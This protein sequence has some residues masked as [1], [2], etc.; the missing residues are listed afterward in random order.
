LEKDKLDEYIQDYVRA[1]ADGGEIV[2]GWV[3]CA[4]VQHAGVAHSDGYIVDTSSGMPYHT[5]IGLLTAGLE[6]KKNI[7]LSQTL[8]G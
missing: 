2:T 1:N 6:E 8:G 7:V 5:Q 3:L 4:S